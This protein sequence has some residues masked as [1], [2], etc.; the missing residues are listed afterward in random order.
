MGEDKKDTFENSSEY[1]EKSASYNEYN[2]KIEAE[3]NSY[4]VENC[5]QVLDEREREVITKLHGI[6]MDRP[7]TMD[8]IAKNLG[9]TKERVRQ[10]KLHAISKMKKAA[11]HKA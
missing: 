7:L 9:I 10:I 3:E 4:K 5:L 6:K 11:T 2:D 8:E 1:N